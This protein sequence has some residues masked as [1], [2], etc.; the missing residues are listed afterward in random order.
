MRKTHT[1]RPTLGIFNTFNEK[2]TKHQHLRRGS[3][4]DLR[5]TLVSILCKLMAAAGASSL[6]ALLSCCC[7]RSDPKLLLLSVFINKSYFYILWILRSCRSSR[8]EPLIIYVLCCNMCGSNSSKSSSA[9][10]PQRSRRSSEAGWQKLKQGQG[11]TISHSLIHSY[12]LI[13]FAHS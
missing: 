13:H 11:P 3:A 10:A 4:S 5:T 8:L 1:R 6:L 2:S 9:A 7:C 12:S